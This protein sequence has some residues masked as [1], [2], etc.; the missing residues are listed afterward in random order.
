[1]TTKRTGILAKKLGMTRIFDE[2]GNH[3]AAT[4]L[5]V[6]GNTVV[7]VRTEEKDGYNAIQLGF[8]KRK[9]KRTTKAVRGYF[10]KQK[11]EPTQVLKEFRVSKDSLLEQ[12]DEVLASHFIV[13]QKVDVSGETLGKGFEG[14]MK[15]W[16]FAG[17][18]ATHGVS[19]SH[20]SHG[21][22]G[23]R[24]D[25]GRVFKG[26]KMAGH[27][28]TNR[29]TIMN[30][31][32]VLVDD[33]QGLIAVEGAVPGFEGAIVQIKD[34]AKKPLHKDVPKPGKVKKSATA[35]APAQ[36][37]E[38]QQQAAQPEAAPAEQQN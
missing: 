5:E 16:N 37:Q 22:T 12:G 23:Q 17:L 7:N 31:K 24:Q 2:Q 19:V 3:V 29:S 18:E 1:M 26:K 34:A 25:P 14:V 11:I 35:A 21:S 9:S 13:G 15:R 27:Q 30:L 6:G 8:G 33:A 20:R 10:A 38:Q 36:Q 4:L 32:V 28:G